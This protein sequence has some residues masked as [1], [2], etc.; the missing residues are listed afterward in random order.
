MGG[1]LFGW[2][3]GWLIGG[4]CWWWIFCLF[5]LGFLASLC[6]CFSFGPCVCCRGSG[7]GGGGAH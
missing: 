6:D 4:F 2:L 1:G 3:V 7:G 5:V